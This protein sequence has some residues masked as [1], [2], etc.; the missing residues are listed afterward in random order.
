MTDMTGGQAIIRTLV[1]HGADVMS[2]LPG[3]Q[4]DNTFDGL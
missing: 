4:L 1:N 3:L 2:G